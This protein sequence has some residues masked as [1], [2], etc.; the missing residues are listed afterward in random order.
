MLTLCCLFLLFISVRTVLISLF[1]QFFFKF[2]WYYFFSI[3][4][5]KFWA[6]IIPKSLFWYH[7]NTKCEANKHLLVNCATVSMTKL[8][9]IVDILGVNL[10]N[11]RHMQMYNSALEYMQKHETEGW[12]VKKK[13]IEKERGEDKVGKTGL[14]CHWRLKTR[15]AFRSLQVQQHQEKNSRQRSIQ[16]LL[17]NL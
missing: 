15:Q 12:T 7:G 9:L 8:L 17:S 3:G 5:E 4:I 11:H 14:C 13:T 6:G 1:F 2:L 16:R 10:Q